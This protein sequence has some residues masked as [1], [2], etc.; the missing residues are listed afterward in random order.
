MFSALR[1]KLGCSYCHRRAWLP[2]QLEQ[3][4]TACRQAGKDVVEEACRGLR[5][6]SRYGQIV[7]IKVSRLECFYL[8]HP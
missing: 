4:V 8:V 3:P 1:N 5:L 7:P 6:S 2:C